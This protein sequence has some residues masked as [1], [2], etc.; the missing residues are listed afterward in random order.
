MKNIADLRQD[1][2]QTQL[3]ES[4]VLPDAIA[5]FQCWF[6]QA[7]EAQVTEPNAMTLAT[8][9]AQGEPSARIVLLKGIEQGDLVFY[10]N[11]Q[12]RKGHDMAVNA[13]VALNFF[14]LPIERQICIRGRVTKTTHE[15]TETYFHS[16]PQSSQLGAWASAQ[17]TVIPSR[18]VLDDKMASLEKQYQD[19]PIPLPD[20]W[21]GYCVE[22]VEIEFWQ[23]RTS[24]LHDR[25]RYTR[26][27]Q[28]G[29]GAPTTRQWQIHRVSP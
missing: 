24:R 9:N 14:W 16:R 19:K 13:N 29:T 27:D 28:P 26:L 4:D 15:Q 7:I 21:G 2:R 6:D 5:Q 8:V 22:P 12:S 20:F 17:S 23:G 10:T 11:Y 18:Q 1:Y 25:L 3:L